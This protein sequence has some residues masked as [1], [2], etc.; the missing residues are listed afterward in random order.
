LAKTTEL[1]SKFQETE[2]SIT[3]K[4]ESLERQLSLT[5]TIQT[6]LEKK[7]SESK[8]RENDVRISLET[9]NTQISDVS[10]ACGLCSDD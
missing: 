9:A 3:Q 7:L 2:K 8:K 5:N 4:M 1:I 6:T 10:D